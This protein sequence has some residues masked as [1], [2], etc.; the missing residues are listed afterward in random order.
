MFIKYANVFIMSNQPL[1]VNVNL[2]GNQSEFS[3]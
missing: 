2:N 3:K 1:N